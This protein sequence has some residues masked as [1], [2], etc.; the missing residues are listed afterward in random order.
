[1]RQIDRTYDV[2]KMRD[3]I[4]EALTTPQKGPKVI[5]ASSECMLN[6]QRRE[7][8][9]RR[10]RSRK[11]AGSSAALW[12][13]RGRLH[14]RSRL[15]AA[16]GLPV[17]VA[18]KAGRSACATIRWP[19]STSCVGCGNCG[20]VADAAILCPS[21]STA[22]MWSTTGQAGNPAGRWREGWRNY[23]LAKRR[24]ARRW[25]WGP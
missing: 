20:E 12:R 7:K 13:G 8:P 6:K 14:R 25:I 10:R 4:R 15:H 24:A 23:R 9:L 19:A 17:L 21:A 16:V 1:V 22:P 5:V 11:A 3:T 18:E 2:A